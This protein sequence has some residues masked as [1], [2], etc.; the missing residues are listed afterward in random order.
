MNISPKGALIQSFEALPQDEPLWLR[1]DHP[2]KTDWIEAVPVRCDQQHGVGVVFRERCRD[3]FLLAAVMG[4][5]FGW[6]VPEQ[7]G[8]T[9]G[10]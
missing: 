3:D 10:D 2:V 5:D 4:L 1:I 9:S 7:N 6:I 8:S